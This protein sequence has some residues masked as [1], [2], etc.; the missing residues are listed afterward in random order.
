MIEREL[1]R[2]FFTMLYLKYL[3]ED[4][5]EYALREMHE[6]DRGNHLGAR[7][8]AYKLLRGGYY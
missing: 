5:V 4:E 8:I 2:H 1:Y 3:I 7:T 6:S